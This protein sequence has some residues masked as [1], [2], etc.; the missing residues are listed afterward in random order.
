MQIDRR[1]V[2]RKLIVAFRNFAIDKCNAAENFYGRNVSR[3]EIPPPPTSRPSFWLGEI[4]AIAPSLCRR[5]EF[6][7]LRP[8]M[9]LRIS[10]VFQGCLNFSN[11]F[12]LNFIYKCGV[13]YFR[14][15]CFLSCHNP[16][17]FTVSA[18]LF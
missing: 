14:Y 12:F 10:F 15:V 7:R 18:V 3:S 8:N 13:V 1:T 9:T 6:V 2:M 11:E 16:Y 4:S 17:A 5:F